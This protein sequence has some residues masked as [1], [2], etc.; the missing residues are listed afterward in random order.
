[1]AGNSGRKLRLVRRVQ[2][3]ARG[4]AARGWL[5]RAEGAPRPPPRAGRGVMDVAV[6][7]NRAAAGNV[8]DAD[9]VR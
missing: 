6:Y 1:M 7:G 2:V 4:L 8:G 5:A 3:V 9:A